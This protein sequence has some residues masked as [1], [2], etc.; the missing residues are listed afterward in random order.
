MP[1]FDRLQLALLTPSVESNS[2]LNPLLVYSIRSRVGC[3]SRFYSLRESSH[4]QYSFYVCFHLLDYLLWLFHQQY[5]FPYLASVTVWLSI[6]LKLEFK[7][8]SFRTLLRPFSN[9][10]AAPETAADVDV[11][12]EGTTLEKI[13]FSSWL[14]NSLVKSLLDVDAVDFRLK[15]SLNMLFASFS[16]NWF[17]SWRPIDDEENRGEL[18]PDECTIKFA[19]RLLSL[20]S[21]W[22]WW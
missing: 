21:W 12:D 15:S 14:N 19:P 17:S 16:G 20:G 8:V 1:V 11:V 2:C 6:E 9:P 7:F 5:L 3:S 4:F 18:T 10:A 22:K 13:F